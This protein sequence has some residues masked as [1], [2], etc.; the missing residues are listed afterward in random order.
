MYIVILGAGEVGYTLAKILCYEN[1]DVALVEQDPKRLKRARDNLDIKVIEGSASSYH[2]LEEAGIKNADIVVA[3]TN[4]DEVNLI[5]CMIANKYEVPKKVVRVKNRE[6]TR[7]SAPL[8]DRIYRSRSSSI[9]T[10]E[11]S[12]QSTFAGEYEVRAVPTG[13]IVVSFHGGRILT[14]T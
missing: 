11:L 7:E 1:Q 8:N 14:R 6:F 13:E 2:S 10:G 3:V 4:N 12:I 9:S 5:A